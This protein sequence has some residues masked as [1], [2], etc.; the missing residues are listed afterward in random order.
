M[1]ILSTARELLFLCRDA[2]GSSFLRAGLFFP[3]TGG[4][5]VGLNALFGRAKEPGQQLLTNQRD[6]APVSA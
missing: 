2:T 6:T 5:L 3:E 4:S 1:S